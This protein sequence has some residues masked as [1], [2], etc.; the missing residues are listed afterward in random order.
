MANLSETKTKDGCFHFETFPL[1][2]LL[3]YKHFRLLEVLFLSI[4]CEEH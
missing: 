2:K 3:L 1:A 4:N